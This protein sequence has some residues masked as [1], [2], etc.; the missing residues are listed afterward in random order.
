MGPSK[1]VINL[2]EKLKFIWD[3]GYWWKG[4]IRW[5]KVDFDKVVQTMKLSPPVKIW[6]FEDEYNKGITKGTPGMLLEA[7]IVLSKEG[8]GNNDPV[9]DETN[10]K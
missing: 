4:W 3:E 7:E 1:L 8:E 2:K 6:Q 10:Q 9:L 5:C